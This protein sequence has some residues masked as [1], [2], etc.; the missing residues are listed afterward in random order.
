[1]IYFFFILFSY[2]LCENSYP[3]FS[4]LKKQFSFEKKRIYIDD[5]FKIIR[6]NT[7]LS[8]EDFLKITDLDET[9]EDLT[10][11]YLDS[12]DVYNNKANEITKVVDYTKKEKLFDLF[13]LSC[14]YV[15]SIIGASMFDSDA[16]EWLA[17]SV[18]IFGTGIGVTAT[19]HIIEEIKGS[20]GP[21]YPNLKK[22]SLNSILSIQ[23]IKSLSEAYNRNIYTEIANNISTQEIVDETAVGKVKNKFVAYDQPP[24]SKIDI[25]K[26][27]KYPRKE[28]IRG[29]E[30]K[31][32][33]E[34]F[35]NE[36]G[37]VVTANV[38]K[39]S[40]NEALDNA[41]LDAV[42]SSKWEPAKQRSESVGVWVTQQIN[43]S[44]SS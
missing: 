21:M 27:I 12:L 13:F 15:S 22:P 42:K 14:G 30:G 2:T 9:A 31:V 1:M 29:I 24:K 8:V 33:V 43:F 35:V 40:G 34:F 6:N 16:P 3:Y 4:D 10:K 5:K 11:L 23:Q 44:L 38:L 19:K 20:Y 17:G 7:E 25:S 39:S 18:L 36:L 28:K 32:Y 26:L 37:F 41:A